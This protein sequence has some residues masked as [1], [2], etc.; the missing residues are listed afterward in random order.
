MERLRRRVPQAGFIAI[1]VRKGP[2]GRERRAV[3][4]TSSERRLARDEG[5]SGLILASKPG[6]DR[7]FWQGIFAECGRA[8][9]FIVVAPDQPHRFNWLDWEAQE[10]CRLPRDCQPHHDGRGNTETRRRRR[11]G[12]RPFFPIATERVIQM[13]VEPL[14]LAT[15]HVDAFDL[16]RFINGMVLTPEQLTSPQWRSE[17]HCKT[18][19]AAYLGAKS[20]IEKA[21]MEQCLEAWLNEYVHL[22]DRTRS[23]IFTQV[24]QT[25]AAFTGG[26]V[27]SMV[28]GKTNISPAAIEDGYWILVD[29]PA[30]RWARPVNSS[31]RCG[32][33][34]LQRHVLRRVARPDS[35]IIVEW[36]DEFQNH[37]NSFDPK[38][39]A[40][41]R[42][43]LGCMVVLTQSLH[44]YYAALSSGRAE[45]MANALLTNLRT[46]SAVCWETPKAQWASDLCGKSRQ[47]LISGSMRPAGSVGR[48]D[49]PYEVHGEFLRAPGEQRRA[50]RVHARPAHRRS[51][52][53]HGGRLGDPLRA[54]VFERSEL[55]SHGVQPEVRHGK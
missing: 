37:L 19:E 17:F 48:D 14:R 34:R 23:S 51:A 53:L 38:Y 42:S 44:S 49:G 32:S 13:A 21:D 35:R 40:E 25:L 45:H 29:M 8:D 1:R 9:A 36:V 3:W 18:L 31:T 39:L 22:N 27:R 7:N 41:C 5:I 26:I 52:F 12:S 11:Q 24:N 55:A 50:G 28:S 54:A 47:I 30:S 33:W 20:E 6:E 43:H 2:A 15:G 10:R 16:Q 4:A 46:A